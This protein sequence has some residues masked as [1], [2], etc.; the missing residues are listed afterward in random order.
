MC[1]LLHATGAWQPYEEE[2]R[3]GDRSVLRDS[4]EQSVTCGVLGCCHVGGLGIA[5]GGIQC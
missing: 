5:K 4:G 2:C 1:T 3:R